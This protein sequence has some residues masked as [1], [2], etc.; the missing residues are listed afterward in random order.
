V[1]TAAAQ[2]RKAMLGTAR[3]DAGSSSFST[4][5]GCCV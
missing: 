4:A 5:S 1:S 3:G 2:G